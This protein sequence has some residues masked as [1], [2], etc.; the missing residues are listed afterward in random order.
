M[1]C[2]VVKSDALIAAAGSEY[3]SFL[4]LSGLTAGLPEQVAHKGPSGCECTAEMVIMTPPTDG[5]LMNFILD[6]TDTAHDNIEFRVTCPA[7]GSLDGAVIGVT[8]R[9]VDQ[10]S[11]GLSTITTT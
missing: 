4:I 5:S 8:C 6:D 2:T 3:V 11:G 9:F 7:G 1:A 10:G